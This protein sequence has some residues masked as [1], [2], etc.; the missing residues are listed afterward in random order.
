MKLIKMESKGDW[1][2]TENFLSRAAKFSVDDI[3]NFY[4]RKGVEALASHT[5]VNTGLTADS[6]G[7]RITKK[8]GN[9]K[10]TWTNSNVNKG[11]S[12]AILLQYGHGTRN[13]GYVTGI[14]YINPALKDIFQQ[15][16]EQA[17]R[18]VIGK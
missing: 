7:Y 6:W 17:W 10:I 8:K 15:I 2:N 12:I 9:T 3:L 11:Y 16:A 1:K 13:G 18:E 5:P 14:D 4:A